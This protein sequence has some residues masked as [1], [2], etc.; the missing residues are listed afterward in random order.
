VTATPSPSAPRP[1]PRRRASRDRGFTIIEMT[2]ALF[3]TAEV[4]LAGLALF[5]FNNRLAHVQTQVSDMQQSLRISQYDMV[6]LTREAGRGFFPAV[7]TPPSTGTLTWGAVSVRDNVVA[8]SNQIALGFTGSPTVVLGTDVLTLR[9]V[10]SSPVYQ[11]NSQAAA[12]TLSGGGAATTPTNATAGTVIVCA[13]TTTGIVQNLSSLISAVTAVTP[14]AI[15]M[16]SALSESTYAVVELNPGSSDVASPTQ[17]GC[18]SPAGAPTPNGVKL[19]FNITGGTHASSFQV[20]GSVA[21]TSGLPANMSGAQWLGILEE[22]RYYVREDYA[23]PGNTASAWA[24]HLS[25]AR[26]YPGT[27]IPYLGTVANLQNDVADNVL[28]LQIALGV[29]LNGDG[30]ITEDSPPDATDE[31]IGN[32]SGDT[33][34]AQS[35]LREVRISTLAKTGNPDPVY[36]APTLTWIEDHNYTTTVWPNTQTGKSYRRRLLQTVVGLRNL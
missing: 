36:S 2:V 21:S 15:I 17:P 1:R 6:R 32:A 35:P 9:G 4:I 5:D 14:E 7:Y 25:R 8:A 19:A 10:F 28:D 12:F 27:E 24:P 11:V 31:W 30:V 29:D 34:T 3:V 23:V 13:Y 20:M 16:T 33:L 26:M 22:Y 18:P